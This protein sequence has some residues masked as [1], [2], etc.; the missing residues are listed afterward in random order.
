LCAPAGGG[1]IKEG[2]ARQFLV[3]VLG[4]A[5]GIKFPS[6]LR[7]AAAERRAVVTGVCAVRFHGTS[8]LKEHFMMNMCLIRRIY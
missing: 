6:I 1:S 4:A 5:L 8:R 3:E 2:E 7:K